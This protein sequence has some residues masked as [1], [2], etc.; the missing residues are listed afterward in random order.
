MQVVVWSDLVVPTE[1]DS[2]NVDLKGTNETK[3]TLS[4]PLT[5]GNE[6]GKTKLPLQI[7]LVPASDQDLWF[8]VKVTGLL[9]GSPVVA[10]EASSSCIVGERLLLPF[11]LGRACRDRQ[12]PCDT[13]FTCS[14]GSCIDVAVAP[15]SL[16]VYT[17]GE[18]LPE[19]DA[20]ASPLNDS[21]LGDSGGGSS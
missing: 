15:S 19:P 21:G 12:P 13:G 1:I 7:S 14:A 16:P 18:S 10:Q 4:F 20:S 9:H 8:D 11:F 2:V 17:P 5:A 3:P 6:S